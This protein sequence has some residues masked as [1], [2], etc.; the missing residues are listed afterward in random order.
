MPEASQPVAGG[1]SG[2][3]PPDSPFSRHPHPGRG[4]SAPSLQPA[5][6]VRRK[7]IAPVPRAGE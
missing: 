3:T 5:Q 1:L 2:A 6:R 7:P 4:A